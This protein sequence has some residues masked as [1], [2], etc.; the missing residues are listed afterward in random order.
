ML[1]P[2]DFKAIGEALAPG[3]KAR[4]EHTCGD[5]K[6][7]IVSKSTNGISAWCFRCNEK[8]FLPLQIPLAERI[9]ALSRARACDSEALQGTA[10]ALQGATLW[11]TSQWPATP[12]LWLFKHGF[13]RDEIHRHGWLWHPGM[14]RVV[15]PVYSEGVLVYWTARGFDPGRPKALN[16]K[17]DRRGLSLKFGEAARCIV[18][19]EDVL[20][21]AKV[22]GSLETALHGVEAH[23]LMGTVLDDALAAQIAGK[24]LPVLLMLDDDAAGRRGAAKAQR[25]LSLLGVKTRQIYFG[26]DPKC[27][28]RKTIAGVINE[29]LS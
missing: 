15:F 12:L 7:L 26:Q 10:T 14:Q 21:A 25:T 27:I 2:Q 3:K 1:Q 22:G 11:D 18:L 16:A 6:T 9:A 23:A 29:E 4:G 17:A 28:D 24:S 20:S 19:T 13:S 5:G 8:G